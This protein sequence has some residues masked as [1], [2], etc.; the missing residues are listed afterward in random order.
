MV[1]CDLEYRPS[2][3]V[4][5]RRGY[6]LLPGFQR[7]VLIVLGFAQLRPC[8]EQLEPG[9]PERRIE[10]Q[11]HRLPIVPTNVLVVGYPRHRLGD[12]LDVGRDPAAIRSGLHP[13]AV[14]SPGPSLPSRSDEIAQPQ[15]QRVWID[16]VVDRVGAALAAR[17]R[18]HDV[19]AL[20]LDLDAFGQLAGTAASGPVKIED[21]VRPVGRAAVL[22]GDN[23][24]MLGDDLVPLRDAVG[25]I[26]RRVDVDA[27]HAGCKTRRQADQVL[28]AASTMPGSGSGSV[29]AFLKPPVPGIGLP[30]ASLSRAGT[31]FLST[32]TGKIGKPC[33]AQAS[34]ASTIRPDFS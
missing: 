31:G 14:K 6:D 16:V 3:G 4:V 22:A 21:Q 30:L 25:M 12:F 13:L 20:A 23:R 24:L 26:L 7:L 15:R 10:P 8:V 29:V 2:A 1:A 33:A 32:V 34:A 18:H 19:A 5:R 27:A 17:R 9:I 28:A 11:R